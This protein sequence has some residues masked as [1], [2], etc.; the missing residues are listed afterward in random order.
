MEFFTVISKYPAYRDEANLQLHSITCKSVFLCLVNENIKS[1]KAIFGFQAYFLWKM[2]KI[3]GPMIKTA[4]R[5]NIRFQGD[6]FYEVGVNPMWVRGIGEAS[7]V[8]QSTA[9]EN[10]MR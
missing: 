8:L 4:Y 5:K 6:C 9:V 1:M 10:C 7:Q 3:G 2:R